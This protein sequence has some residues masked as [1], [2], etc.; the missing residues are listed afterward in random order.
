MT[1][2]QLEECIKMNRKLLL[3]LL[4]LAIIP[5][6]VFGLNQ[7]DADAI[8]KQF[9]KDNPGVRIG[10]HTLEEDISEQEEVNRSS[11]IVEGKILKAN[12]YWKIIHEGQPPRIFTDYIVQVDEVI[13][14]QHKKTIK[15][16]MS[17]G[18]L[19]GI[20]SMTASPELK[21]G[22]RVIMLLGQDLESSFMD[23]YTPVSI[24]KS[25]YVVDENGNGKNKMSERNDQVDKIKSRIAN[26]A[27]S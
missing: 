22:D 1:Y 24:S 21:K 13:K 10:V 8:G 3:P 17:G 25:T 2:P 16:T 6:L 20:T 15:V 23:S 5:A 27:I 4:A 14:G 12:A 7:P 9:A 11:L 18:A 26:L 19:D